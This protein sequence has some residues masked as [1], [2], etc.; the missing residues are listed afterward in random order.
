MIN[1]RYI[2]RQTIALIEEEE[3]DKQSTSLEF[4]M[5]KPIALN[6]GV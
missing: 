4:E 3:E 5:A 1:W 6:R 2:Q